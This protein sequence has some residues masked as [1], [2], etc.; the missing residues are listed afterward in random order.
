MLCTN[1]T[2][3][4]PILYVIMM[5]PLE[6]FLLRAADEEV[7]YFLGHFDTPDLLLLASLNQL[8]RHWFDS[9]SR[10]AWSFT[11]F[12]GIY[13]SRPVSLLSLMDGKNALLFGKAVLAFV[14]R[15][16]DPAIPMD[17]SVNVTKIGLVNRVLIDDGFVRSGSERNKSFRSFN[18]LVGGIVHRIQ[19]ANDGTWANSGD[20]TFSRSALLGRQ[21]VYR[22]RIEGVQVRIRVHLVRCEP[23]RYALESKNSEFERIDPSRS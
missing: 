10:R 1:P 14:L 21:F 3:S 6:S 13:V 9:Y 18:D 11:E 16:A 23:H 20:R 19:L 15:C 12:V 5:S 4:L 8:M 22:K 7:E 17:I 2:Q